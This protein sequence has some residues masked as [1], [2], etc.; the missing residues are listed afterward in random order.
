MTTSKKL[1]DGAIQKT[2]TLQL[3]HIKILLN[4]D[5]N[6]LNVFVKAKIEE[7]EPD[8]IDKINIEVEKELEGE[9]TDIENTEFDDK[10]P[11]LPN[12]F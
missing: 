9:K 1:K 2:I 11:T 8:K 3:K 7:L 12:I 4:N 5:I 10:E 6:D